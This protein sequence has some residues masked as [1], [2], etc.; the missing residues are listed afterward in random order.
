MKYID[1]HI[2]SCFSDGIYHPN[3]LPAHCGNL[4]YIGVS[5]HDTVAGVPSAIKAFKNSPIKIIPGVELSCVDDLGRFPKTFHILGLGINHQNQVLQKKLE[6]IREKSKLRF[7][8]IMENL[9]MHG[10]EMDRSVLNKEEGIITVFDIFLSII[11]APDF[12]YDPNSYKS[13]DKFIKMWIKKSS[14]YHIPL[15][16]MTFEEAIRLIHTADGKAILAHPGHTLQNKPDLAKLAIKKMINAGLNG[17]EVFT[18]KHNKIETKRFNKIADENQL[19]KT[20][21]SDFHGRGE[22]KIGNI[23]TYG[24]EFNEMETIEKILYE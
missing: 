20:C 21:G 8:A 22:Q 16:K 7:W 14:K 23:N 12:E 6:S 11:Y 24:L 15:K 10:Y 17:I 2:H 1:L 4:R 19:L 5:D 9:K 18:P 13:L 3:E